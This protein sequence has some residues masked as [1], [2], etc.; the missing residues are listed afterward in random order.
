VKVSSGLA[1]TRVLLITYLT[2]H[3][4]TRIFEIRNPH[5]LDREQAGSC[6]IPNT[7]YKMVAT[8]LSRYCA[9]LVTWRPELLPDDDAWSRSLYEDVKKDAERVL[10][11]RTEEDSLTPEANYQQVI[12]QVL[13]ADAKHDLLM[14]GASLG[15][16]LVELMIEGGEDAVWKLLAEFWSEMI[17]YVTP[18]DNLKGHS[19]AIASGGELITLLW[20]L[21]FHAGIVSRPGED[22]GVAPTSAGVV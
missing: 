19:E 22:D 11:G 13:S 4:A 21:L 12:I 8:H 17:V 2:W 10:A 20:V 14:E 9:Y 1:I 16:Q 18:S 3:I 5:R 15:K 7:D 6:P